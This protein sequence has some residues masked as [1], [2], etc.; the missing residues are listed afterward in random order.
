MEKLLNDSVKFVALTINP[1]VTNGVAWDPINNTNEKVLRR[2]L[3]TRAFNF[4]DKQ[5]LSILLHF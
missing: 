5:S 2:S 3:Y 4:V 1:P